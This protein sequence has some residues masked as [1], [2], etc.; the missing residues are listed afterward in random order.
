[1][2]KDMG[3]SGLRAPNIPYFLPHHV[4]PKAPVSLVKLY[5][6]KVIVLIKRIPSLVF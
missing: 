1:M 3:L 6:I 2:G 5:A 4:I